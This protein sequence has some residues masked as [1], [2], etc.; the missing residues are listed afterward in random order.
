MTISSS[1]TTLIKSSYSTNFYY[2]AMNFA[3]NKMYG[4]Y[5]MLHYPLF[6]SKNDDLMQ[7]QSNL[8][9]YCVSKLPSLKNKR[10]LDIG[11]GNGV[12]SIYLCNN[13]SPKHVIG[14]DINSDSISI[15]Q[16]E[17]NNN[18]IDKVDFYVDN[19]QDLVNIED[20]SID[21]ILNIESAF[22]YPDK[23]SFIN[24]ISRVL[25]P[26][27][28]FLIADIL[29]T[30][31]RKRRIIPKFW[32]RK[33]NLHH[34][35]FEDYKKTFLNS[36]LKITSQDDITRLIV[37]GFNTYRNWFQT[38]KDVGR[39]MI[40]LIKIFVYLNVRLNVFLFKN[41]RKYMIFSGVKS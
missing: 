7:A 35:S 18:N 20:N 13:Y 21:V 27:G 17:K 5:N 34:W 12:Q 3:F 25:K 41:R 37:N 32:K 30:R 16:D 29:T 2:K 19:A 38:D 26:K 39:M 31:K 4:R 40:M 28:Y 24:E 11:C 14:V 6:K 1:F 9:D 15:A 8:T 33:M 36:E 10:I 22:H 23:E